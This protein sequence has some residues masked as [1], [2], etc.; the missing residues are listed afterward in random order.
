MDQSAA[1]QRNEEDTGQAKASSLTL[2][3][4]LR[5]VVTPIEAVPDPVFS[6]RMVGE[7]V[8]LDP[9]ENQLCAP[10]DGEVALLPNSGHAVTIR[11][12]SGV[13]ILMH[14]GLDT[15][16]LAGEGF[17]PLA[18]VGDTVS[19]GDP[20]IDFDLDFVA[21]K[22]KSLLTQIV[23][24]NSDAITNFQPAT[25]GIL[26]RGGHL[27]TMDVVD[28]AEAEGDG[29]TTAS[30]EG[31][32]IGNPSGLH[33]R[34][35]AVLVGIAKQY[36]AR[37]RLHRGDDSANAK[38]VVGIMG[39]EVLHGDKVTLVAT[40]H[41]ADAAVAELSAAIRDGLG[42]ATE[43]VEEAG[44]SAATPAP[45]P[46]RRAAA[47]RSDD[48]NVLIGVSA[49]PGLGV[50]RVLQLRRAEIELKEDA[51]DKH[52]ERRR[53]N[54][55]I[56]RAQV[57]LQSLESSLENPEK[58]AIFAAH[59]E[60][61]ADPDLL[62]LV[63]SAIEKGK[64]AEYAWRGAYQS[65]ADQLA[66]LSNEVLA[67]R[68]VDVRDVGMRVL[69]ELT[70]HRSEREEMD[71]GTIL[72]AEDL[73]PSDTATLDREKVAGFATVNGGAS[74][75]VA[76]LAR[77]LDIPAIAGIE[78]RALDLPDGDRVFLDGT[79]GTLRTGIS[80]EEVQTIQARQ[81]RIEARRAEERKHAHE[82]AHTSDGHKVLVVANIGGLDDARQAMDSGAEGVGL[83]RSEFLFMGRQQAPTED[84][85]AELYH[86]IAETQVGKPLVI[87][88]LDVGGD[89]PLPY[90]PI[91]PEENPFLGLRGVRVGLDR[92]E[93][94]RTQSR[95]ILQ[96]VK[97]GADIHVM[98]PMVATLPDFRQAREIFEEERR[99]LGVSEVPLGVMVEVPSVAVMAEQFAREADFF[100]VGTNDMTQYTLAM[101]RGHPMLAPQVDALNPAVLGL[102]GR[103][104]EAAHRHDRWIGVCGGVASDPQAVPLLVG[105]GV[106]ELS[107][108]IPSVA[109]VKAR[110]RDYSLEQCRTLA[111]EALRQSTAAEVR[112][113]VPLEED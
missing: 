57:E 49:S 81:A 30:S 33:A 73:T 90:L 109:T 63:S 27:A 79:R 28:V 14:I 8:S 4:P 77:S 32:L 106:D 65:F 84:E 96:A 26:A 34:P 101:D 100:S 38:S 45:T 19:A 105:L 103:A 83:L 72:I 62:D 85:Q 59:R 108:S 15:V 5:G 31:I 64:T 52:R 93:I 12:A 17:T 29:G 58:A 37:I 50:G 13:E 53:L 61:L 41:D 70:G 91:A 68:A 86:A 69:E 36:D 47:P 48:P 11:H 25:S 60:L 80:E 107:C 87:R 22:A 66:G 102:I 39:M 95:A 78:P 111:D 2:Q 24:S 35:T 113:L 1:P 21:Q 3:A 55:A 10:C 46:S 71:A 98:F 23:I 16:A 75:H 99:R 110:V 92:P 112:D 56:D 76:I 6:R 9:L 20:L 74:S 18:R 67:G 51:S 40:G 42:E 88:T 44:S 82:P 94:L 7:G 54:T 89:K 97:A 43:P 104:A